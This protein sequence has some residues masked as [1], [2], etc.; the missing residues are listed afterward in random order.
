MLQWQRQEMT[1]Q[2]MWKVHIILAKHDVILQKYSNW[3]QGISLNWNQ[4]KIYFG[5]NNEEV[6]HEFLIHF[7]YQACRPIDLWIE[8][9]HIFLFLCIL[10]FFAFI[11][12]R[13]G[14][15]TWGEGQKMWRFHNIFV[16]FTL[17]MGIWRKPGCKWTAVYS[18]APPRWVTANEHRVSC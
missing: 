17:Y 18:K 7:L 8:L 5:V 2:W 9:A 16:G 14:G 6:I 15:M 13:F 1:C 10:L 3:G 12:G 11:E 4:R